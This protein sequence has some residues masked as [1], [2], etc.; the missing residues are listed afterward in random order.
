M[1]LFLLHLR[2]AMAWERNLG[3]GKQMELGLFSLEQRQ[4]QTYQ[5]VLG[6]LFAVA[7]GRVWGK[8]HKL[9]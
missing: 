1:G 4:F 8:G 3:C 7:Y 5:E 6:A 2:T 9:Q